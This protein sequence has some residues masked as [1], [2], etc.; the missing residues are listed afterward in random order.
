MQKAELLL[1]GTNI[2]EMYEC[3]YIISMMITN[4]KSIY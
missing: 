1:K 3:G 2:N 4:S